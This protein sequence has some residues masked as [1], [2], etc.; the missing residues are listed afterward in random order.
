MSSLSTLA[1]APITPIRRTH[2]GVPQKTAEDKMLDQMLREEARKRDYGCGIPRWSVYYSNRSPD[3]GQRHLTGPPAISQAARAS[4][5]TRQ[6]KKTE[7]CH[8][9]R[10]SHAN[11]VSDTIG[12]IISKPDEEPR[13]DPV[14]AAAIQLIQACDVDGDGMLDLFE[15]IKALM[16]RP[17]LLLPLGLGAGSTELQIL[18]VIKKADEDSS[19]QVTKEELMSFLLKNQ[20][21]KRGLSGMDQGYKAFDND[22]NHKDPIVPQ[23]NFG[24]PLIVRP[25]TREMGMPSR[26][27]PQNHVCQNEFFTKGESP[28]ENAAVMASGYFKTVGRPFEGEPRIKTTQKPRMMGKGKEWESEIQPT[29]NPYSR[30]A[31]TANWSQALRPDA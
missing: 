22:M 13:T 30:R 12:N 24:E 16:H 21:G 27:F 29:T 9:F 28:G 23:R 14:E 5:R 1:P 19:G 4:L 10:I 7:Q 17:H 26:R 20:T 11:L 3:Q 2:M 15:I 6:Y 25:A 31:R 8:Q 18:N